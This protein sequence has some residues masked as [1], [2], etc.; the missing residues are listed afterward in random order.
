[1][2]YK[3][4]FIINNMK[5]FRNVLIVYKE[6]NNDN[7]YYKICY[8]IKHLIIILIFTNILTEDYSLTV[9]ILTSLVYNF[10]KFVN[11]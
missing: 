1:M 5:F 3:I 2:I 4:I 8:A 6:K 11:L 9:H 7:R 10:C